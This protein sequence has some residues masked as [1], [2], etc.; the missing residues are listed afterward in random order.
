MRVV[1]AIARVLHDVTGG[2]VEIIV[3]E[4]SPARPMAWELPYAP[5]WDAPAWD[6]L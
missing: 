1:K 3:G 2:D 4:G 5:S 6:D